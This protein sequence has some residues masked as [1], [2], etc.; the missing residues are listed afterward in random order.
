MTDNR[1]ANTA[2]FHKFVLRMMPEWASSIP[3]GRLMA[4]ILAQAWF[5]GYK[6]E[7]RRFFRNE[8][9]VL[10]KYCSVCGLDWEQM[11][12]IYERNCRKVR[13]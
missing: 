6:D 3:E 5:E 1:Y 7:N 12:G 9:K 8:T 10:E 11:V 13:H 2:Q 4:G